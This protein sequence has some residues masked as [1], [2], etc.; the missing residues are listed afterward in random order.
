MMTMTRPPDG[1]DAYEIDVVALSTE[2]LLQFRAELVASIPLIAT[3]LQDPE[4]RPPSPE[5]DSPTW[6]AFRAWRR[7]ARWALAL[8]RSQLAR[9][10]NALTERKA[11]GTAAR[12][13]RL[14]DGVPTE[15]DLQQQ[16]RGRALREAL[17][18]QSDMALLLRAYRI[19]RHLLRDG[20]D[21]P[22]TLD[23]SDREALSRLSIRLRNAYGTGRLQAFVLGTQEATS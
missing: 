13:L 6:Q 8:K 20:E 21:L 17:A 7:R 9:V 10:K 11:L 4:R 5:D 3:Q 18:S 12:R 23:E 19:I 1:L 2:A 22:E 16:A 15:H 14:A